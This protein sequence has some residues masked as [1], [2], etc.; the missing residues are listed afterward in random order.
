MIK[1]IMIALIIL[2]FAIGIYVYPMM[3]DKI[4]SH[5]DEEGQVDG[6]MNRFWGLFLFPFVIVGLSLL[7]F[8]IPKIDPLKNNIEKFRTYYDR[9][10][11]L[12][13]LYLFLVN[14]FVIAWNLSY[15]F[16]IFYFMMPALGFIFYYAGILIEN[17]KMNWFI[18]IRTP[19]TLSN[20]DVW[21]KTNKIG[22]R[23]FK[24]AGFITFLGTF[25]NRYA[26]FFI[27][28]PILSITAFT[29]IY[30]YFEYQK[31]IEHP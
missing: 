8:L 27:L 9:F 5:W 19:W 12:F 14:I 23:F 1:I 24:I 29:V 16:N 7:F 10:I 30:S 31:T 11:I 18:G 4:A 28:V 26:I 17:A 13:F 2:S 6:Y 15:K 21:D 20:E 22:G 25:F 3:P